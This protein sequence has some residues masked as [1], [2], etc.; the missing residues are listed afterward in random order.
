[1]NERVKFR[2]VVEFDYYDKNGED[3]SK[4]ALIYPMAIYGNG[5]ILI[6]RDDLSE[7]L[8]ENGFGEEETNWIL[9]NYTSTD[10]LYILSTEEINQCVGLRDVGGKL[11]YE[12]DTVKYKVLYNDWTDETN[13]GYGVVYFDDRQGGF[14]VRI[15]NKRFNSAFGLNSLVEEIEVIGNLLNTK[16]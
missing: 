3:C 2:A 6:D 10:D 12:G 7:Q 14:G 1:M 11:I 5:S 13:E 16:E 15:T 9:D 4:K 8:K